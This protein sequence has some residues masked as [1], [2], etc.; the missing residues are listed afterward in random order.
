MQF[1][2]TFKG[3]LTLRGLERSD[4][5]PLYRYR[6]DSNEYEGVKALLKLQKSALLEDTYGFALLVMFVAEWYRRDRTGGHWDWIRPLGEIGIA[7]ESNSQRSELAYPHLRYMVEQGLGLWKR[8]L[9][10][11]GQLLYSVVGEA[12]FPVAALQEG[13]LGVWL[14]RSVIAIEK[15]ALPDDAVSNES[16]RISDRHT[17]VMFDAAVDLCQVAVALRKSLGQNRTA[18]TDEQ[19]TTLLDRSAAGWRDK[20]PFDVSDKGF[21]TLFRDLMDAK[22]DEAATTKA[23]RAVRTIRKMEAG[24]WKPFAGVA[25]SGHVAPPNIA[26][27]LAAMLP[28][29]DRVRLIGRGA[30]AEFGHPLAVLEKWFSDGQEKWEVRPLVRETH[31]PLDLSQ[32]VLLGAS[33]AGR[34]IVEFVPEGGQSLLDPVIAFK[35]D[36]DQV[37]DIYELQSIGSS[38][39]RTRSNFLALAI[40]SQRTDVAFEGVSIELGKLGPDYRLV[41]FSGRA[42]FEKG[43]VKSVWMTGADTDQI[44][45]I[46]VSGDTVNSTRGTVYFGRPTIWL[47]KDGLERK[48]GDRDIRWRTVGSRGWRRVSD[49]EPSGFVELAATEKDN[50]VATVRLRMLPKSIRFEPD[51]SRK[52]LIIDGHAGALVN[53]TKDKPLSV[54]RDGNAIVVDLA[55]HRR[56]EEVE[57]EFQWENKV[58]LAVADPFAEPLLLAPSGRPHPHR[59]LIAIGRLHGYSLLAPTE[60]PLLLEARNR[61]T[62]VAHAIVLINCSTPLMCLESQIRE[63]LGTAA[64]IDAR[65]RL[66]WEGHSGHFAE[67]GWYDSADGLFSVIGGPSAKLSAISISSP[68]QSIADMPQQERWV[69]QGQLA[70]EIGPGP[71]LVF[72]RMSDATT[73][74]P[75]VVPELPS[76]ASAQPR[77]EPTALDGIIRL[78]IFAERCHLLMQ[79]CKDPSQ[80]SSDEAKKVIG[81]CRAARQHAVPFNTFDTLTVVGNH[82]QALPYLLAACSSRDEQAAVLALQ[83]EL[84]F[85]WCTTP[86]DA[87]IAAF[88]AAAERLTAQLAVLGSNEGAEEARKVGTKRLDQIG[89]LEAGVRP[90]VAVLLRM[91]FSAQLNGIEMEKYSVGPRTLRSCADAFVARYGGQRSTVGTGSLAKHVLRYQKYWERYDQTF[92]DAIAAPIVAAQMAADHIPYTAQTGRQLRAVWHLDRDHFE[93]SFAV[94]LNNEATGSTYIGGNK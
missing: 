82:P 40:A 65:V 18:T 64:S 78:P 16:R 90:H 67:I 80:W 24:R 63:L 83:S 73:I 57:L 93:T 15:G 56:G 29:L 27:S 20:L 10:S 11:R 13:R 84:P 50:V 7:F 3:L 61:T 76:E 35:C 32:D 86:I 12:G 69:V 54:S 74:R 46:G 36:T 17:Q 41:A 14:R 91:K 70:S 30:W 4:G 89:D 42:T 94:A 72:G 5:R 37:D 71:W 66:A 53:G 9:I 45:E 87:W 22:G 39:A 77:S 43:G 49:A 23:L 2:A 38:S 60:R 52:A 92:W 26:P 48:V 25:F 62:E 88:S 51:K 31:H 75:Q 85:L 34:A 33:T 81:M 6:F 19:L 58:S 8:P 28:N 79:W 68:A 1:R 59:G 44:V 55:A 21:F 47:S